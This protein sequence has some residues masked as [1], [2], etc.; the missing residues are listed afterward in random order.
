MAENVYERV[1]DYSSVKVTLA[2]PNEIR[3][4]TDGEDKKHDTIN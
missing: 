3:A 1:N 4:W 2:S